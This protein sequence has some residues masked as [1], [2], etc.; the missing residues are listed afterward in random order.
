MDLFYREYVRK[1]RLIRKV[2]LS[3]FFV[4][5]GCTVLTFSSHIVILIV[6]KS[7]EA[8]CDN[9]ETE[10]LSSKT[11]VQSMKKNHKKH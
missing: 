9:S 3:F 8:A 4:K 5:K 10:C 11:T 7:R 1:Y 6:I 2:T